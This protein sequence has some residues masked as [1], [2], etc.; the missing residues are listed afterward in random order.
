MRK[1]LNTFSS[2]ACN[3]TITSTKKRLKH[4]NLATIRKAKFKGAHEMPKSLQI[5]KNLEPKLQNL[6]KWDRVVIEDYYHITIM[7]ETNTFIVKFS[8]KP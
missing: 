5:V 2:I 1:S 6:Q 7:D 3:T 8:S 4:N